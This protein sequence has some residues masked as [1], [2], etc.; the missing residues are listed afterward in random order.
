M[1]SS[2]RYCFA[3]RLVGIDVN[4]HKLREMLLGERKQKQGFWSSLS[5]FQSTSIK[6]ENSYIKLYI[7]DPFSRNDAK[8]YDFKEIY[9]SED[10]EDITD[11]ITGVIAPK[12]LASVNCDRAYDYQFQVALFYSCNMTSKRE[13]TLSKTTFTMTDLLR[14]T[15]MGQ[16]LITK[17][18]DEY[19]QQ[20]KCVVRLTF[21]GSANSWD[22]PQ[23]R[24][25]AAPKATNPLHSNYV[26]YDSPTKQQL[27][28]DP[29]VQVDEFSIE[30]KFAF[31]VPMLYLSVVSKSLLKS[32]N[33]WNQRLQFEKRRQ[34]IFKSLD[35]A[36]SYG[37]H[38]LEIKVLA[39]KI[40][41]ENIEPD[42]APRRRTVSGSFGDSKI[43]Q[44]LHPYFEDTESITYERCDNF[45]G[46]DNSFGDELSA[47][48]E[49]RF[50]RKI[51]REQTSL[52]SHITINLEDELDFT[53]ISVP[54]GRTNTE[55]YNNYPFYG[56]NFCADRIRK[57]AKDP[58][59]YSDSVS[60]EFEE[61]DQE[62]ICYESTTKKDLNLME[63]Y[64]GPENIDTGKCY[65]FLTLFIL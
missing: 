1:D 65:F 33:A 20:S 42:I 37:W 39:A 2:V 61:V 44:K 63:K 53:N 29:V 57:P 12:L 18:S 55:Y 30:P 3:V 23:F 35:E 8:S 17:L 19:I 21:D 45:S 32:I 16:P 4:K 60:I 48:K 46:R 7:S 41:C 25:S 14:A 52:C 56:S 6:N 38:K 10:F 54:I 51:A 31:D 26:F 40:D 27:D 36:F 5:P 22:L 9:C 28:E 47:Y 62:F 15:S 43:Y 50:E 59:A 49:G 58:I 13:I 11:N 34:G 24:I 64:D